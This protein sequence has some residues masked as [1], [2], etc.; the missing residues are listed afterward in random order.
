MPKPYGDA[1]RD[2]PKT[3]DPLTNLD[4]GDIETTGPTGAAAGR[5]IDVKAA[6]LEQTQPGGNK[7]L[8]YGSTGKRVDQGEQ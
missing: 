3:Y 7:S 8:R 4:H 1:S 5:E 6:G 2:Y